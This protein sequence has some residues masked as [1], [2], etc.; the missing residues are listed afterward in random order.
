[1]STRGPS[2]KPAI[3]PAFSYDPYYR[4]GYGYGYGY[5]QEYDI[6]EYRRKSYLL[7]DD[8]YGRT[9]Y[10]SRDWWREDPS[11]WDD[12]YWGG[13][14]GSRYGSR[15]RRHRYRDY[16]DYDP[17]HE[18]W[19][20]YYRGYGKNSWWWW[21]RGQKTHKGKRDP[22]ATKED[23]GWWYS[24]PDEPDRPPYYYDLPPPWIRHQNWNPYLWR[25]DQPP[26]FWMHGKDKKWH[27]EFN[28]EWERWYKGDSKDWWKNFVPANF[29]GKVEDLVNQKLK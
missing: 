22:N 23:Y 24:T 16:D 15:Y 13:R 18:H 10:W 27:W 26:P 5:D 17:Y 29:K 28:K 1:M 8:L 2:G 25:R 12:Y 11:W 14:L 19:D 21:T 20:P 9:P 3:N 6:D 4:Y 7:K